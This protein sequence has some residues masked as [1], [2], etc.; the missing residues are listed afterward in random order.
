MKYKHL[1]NLDISLSRIGLG[2]EQLGCFGWHNLSEQE[3]IKVISRALDMGIN[4]FDTS[5]SYGLGH[6]EE[7]LGRILGTKRKDII[8]ATKIGQ[9]WREKNKNEIEVYIDCSPV[10]INKQIDDSLKRLKTDYI[11]IYQVHW[12]DP[13]TPVKDTIIAMAKLKQA[14]KIRYIGCCNFPTLLLKE[15]LKYAPVD[16]VQMPYNLIDREV[17]TDLLPFCC[18]KGISIIAYTPLAKGLLAG[19]YDR[20]VKFGDDDRRSRH[21]Y[22]QGEK[23]LKNLEVV[24]RVRSIAKK[25]GRTPVQI[26]IRWVL[27]NDA[28]ATTLVGVRNTTQLEGDIA[29]LDF[30]L[31]Q[32]DREFL[33]GN[34]DYNN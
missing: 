23:L 22:F 25:Q 15:A 16:F 12:P 10:N 17:E 5:P 32:I 31:S 14:G 6:S 3:L 13:N 7:M 8:I 11:D 29:A 4:L 9:T 1:A 27:E 28:I 20:D 30:N 33:D 18:E 2:G 26:A 34:D 21:S 24:S 19:K